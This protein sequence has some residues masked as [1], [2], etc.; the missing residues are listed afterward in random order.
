MVILIITLIIMMS[1]LYLSS[2]SSSSRNISSR[3]R[4]RESRITIGISAGNLKGIIPM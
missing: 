3:D 2:R 4:I 1:R